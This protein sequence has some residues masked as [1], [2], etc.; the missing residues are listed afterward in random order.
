MSLPKARKF[1]NPRTLSRESCGR[2]SA[3]ASSVSS[4]IG[5]REPTAADHLSD[6]R[7]VIHDIVHGSRKFWEATGNVCGSAKHR[8]ASTR[9]RSLMLLQ[10]GA[11]SVTRGLR[12][13]AAGRRRSEEALTFGLRAKIDF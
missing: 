1:A 7:I 9:Q 2:F 4:F 6:D 11:K 8:D 5:R 12:H 3:G 10:G 13:M